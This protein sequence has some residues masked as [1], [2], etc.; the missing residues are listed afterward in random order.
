MAGFHL[1][2]ARIDLSPYHSLDKSIS[3]LCE[4]TEAGGR[5]AWFVLI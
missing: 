2:K 1:A 5:L 3:Y 4:G